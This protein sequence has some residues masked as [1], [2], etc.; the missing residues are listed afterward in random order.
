M[1]HRCSCQD[2][3]EA[4]GY[5]DCLI[6]KEK[7]GFTG[8]GLF[9]WVHRILRDTEEAARAQ[10]HRDWMRIWDLEASHRRS[11]CQKRELAQAMAEQQ[12]YS[13]I[14]T[15]CDMRTP[16][17]HFV[18]CGDLASGHPGRSSVEGG[19]LKNVVHHRCL[20]CSNRCCFPFNPTS[21]DCAPK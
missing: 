5:E 20:L 1:P 14:D 17:H 16:G 19:M 15:Q 8:A 3:C 9:L 12:K 18:G 13:D 10:V 2:K 7:R 21:S 4:Q 6:C 11:F